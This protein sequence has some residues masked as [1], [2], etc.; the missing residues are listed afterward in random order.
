LERFNAVL[1]PSRTRTPASNG[2]GP[3]PAI[4]KL[5]RVA[6]ICYTQFCNV[7]QEIIGILTRDRVPK[8]DLREIRRINDLLV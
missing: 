5:S 3:L 7:E 1:E 4:A 2:S 8:F 6:A